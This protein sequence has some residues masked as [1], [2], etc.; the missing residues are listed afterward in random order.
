MKFLSKRPD[1]ICWNTIPV[2]VALG[3]L[4][5]D[6]TLDIQLYDTYYVIEYRVLS[7]TLS[8]I[9]V[10]YAAIYSVSRYAQ[11]QIRSSPVT[12]QMLLTFGGIL[13][14]MF[15]FFWT[16]L[17]SSDVPR[18][19]YVYSRISYSFIISLLM[20]VMAIATG[21]LLMIFNLIEGIIRRSRAM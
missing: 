4:F 15:I 21:F 17:R 9:M 19:M 18:N 20:A 6:H 7:I 14:L 2:L 5:G 13:L 10:L 1:L 8:F 12:W 11:L 3:I 16:G